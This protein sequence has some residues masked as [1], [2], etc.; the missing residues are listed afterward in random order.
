M[1]VVVERVGNSGK[2]EF[3]VPPHLRSE[4]FAY[5]IAQALNNPDNVNGTVFTM[6]GTETHYALVK[7]ATKRTPDGKNIGL[8]IGFAP[9]DGGQQV[10][11]E[12]FHATNVMPGMKIEGEPIVL[13]N[14]ELLIGEDV[15][16]FNGQDQTGKQR[17]VS[18][19]RGGVSLD[20]AS[21]PQK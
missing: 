5:R 17:V 4:G 21:D 15:V 16:H 14:P 7:G 20:T 2:P 9:L 19:G 13:E 10:S 12:Q 1:V 3:K 6:G 8:R 18:V 11:I